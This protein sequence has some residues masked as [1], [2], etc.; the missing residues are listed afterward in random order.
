MRRIRKFIMQAI[1]FSAGCLLALNASF[2]MDIDLRNMP[3]PDKTE[4][5]WSGK[6]FEMNNRKG[7]AAH[8]RAQQKV[9]SELESFYKGALAAQGWQ[10]QETNQQKNIISFKKGDKFIYILLH[11]Q[12]NNPPCDIFFLTSNEDLGVCLELKDYYLKEMVAPDAPGKDFADVLAYPGSKRRFNLMVPE[13]SGILLYEADARLEDV[14]NFYEQALK[15]VGWRL[16]PRF[17]EQFLKARNLYSPE[18]RV[19]YFEKG[20]GNLVI[21]V[22]PVYPSSE[23][24]RVFITIVKNAEEFVNQER[25]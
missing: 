6:P 24:K 23:S 17:K 15:A 11:D 1:I 18:S 22:H 8:L 12:G 4:V 10:F 16:N 2:S 7:L 9:A 21:T 20:K 19:L 3:V 14:A 13:A 25:N 5:L